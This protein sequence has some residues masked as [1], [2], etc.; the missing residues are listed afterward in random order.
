MLACPSAEHSASGA[1]KLL[2]MKRASSGVMADAWV[3]PGGKVDPVDVVLAEEALKLGGLDPGAEL[4]RSTY[5]EMA[6]L[7]LCAVR[8]TLEETSQAWPPHMPEYAPEAA[9][10]SKPDHA[11]YA[12]LKEAAARPQALGIWAQ[13][14]AHDIV[15]SDALQL[16]ANFTTPLSEPRRFS[17]AFFVQT[18]THDLS[19]DPAWQRAAE[20]SMEQSSGEV[21][22][23]QW[24]SPAAA[25]DAWAE[26]SMP[27]PPPQFLLLHTLNQTASTLD[28]L[29]GLVG[30]H[31]L[32]DSAELQPH[33]AKLSDTSLGIHLPGDS[34]HPSAAQLGVLPGK[35]HRLVVTSRSGRALPDGP[36]PP[37]TDVH[38]EWHSD[39][40]ESPT[41]VLVAWPTCIF[42]YV[43]R[44]YSP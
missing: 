26:G 43:K 14:Y 8:E 29:K 27:L 31:A 15:H 9:A 4:G 40:S 36:L 7:R 23:V 2:F 12:A 18:T 32:P 33:N 44:D 21:T 42:K 30:S 19:S 6:Q 38:Y 20:A 35:R 24:A 25:L 28:A 5:L 10:L 13:T 1:Y 17:T 41:A 16:M 3:F 22:G 34:E 37:M 11:Q 39:W